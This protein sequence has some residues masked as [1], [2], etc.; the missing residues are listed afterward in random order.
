MSAD[1]ALDDI[2]GGPPG[3]RKG[4]A[5]GAAKNKKKGRGY[6]DVMAK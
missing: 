5:A 1:S 3:P 4:G 2:L 6:I